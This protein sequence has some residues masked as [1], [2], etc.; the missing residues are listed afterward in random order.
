MGGAHD[1]DGFWN[2]LFENPGHGN[3]WVA[4]DL[5]GVAANRAAIGARIKVVV[6][7][8]SGNGTR[9]ERS[10]YVTVGSGGSF[11]A[12]SLRQEI[13]LGDATGIVAVE[14]VWP[15]SDQVQKVEGLEPRHFYKIRQGSAPELLELASFK[16][17]GDAA[18]EHHHPS[19]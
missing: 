15:G 3:A 6:K 10:I 4:L 16:L 13:G 1:G 9:G 8:P 12:S 2:A 17:T 7:T 19:P 14:I 5:E 18:A 11:G